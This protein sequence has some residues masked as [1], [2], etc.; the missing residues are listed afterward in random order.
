M[1]YSHREVVVRIGALLF[2]PFRVISGGGDARGGSVWWTTAQLAPVPLPWKMH[3]FRQN[4][5]RIPSESKTQNSDGERFSGNRKVTSRE[6]FQHTMPVPRGISTAIRETRDAWLAGASPAVF[7]ETFVYDTVA[8]E[9][10][11]RWNVFQ[12]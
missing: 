9:S 6:Y 8:G 3:K 4:E 1:L 10:Y 2:L 7:G 12:S 11:I 5:D